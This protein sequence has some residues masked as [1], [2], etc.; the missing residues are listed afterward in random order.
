MKDYIKTR[1]TILTAW[2]ESR[3]LVLQSKNLDEFLLRS[4]GLLTLSRLLNLLRYTGDGTDPIRTGEWLNE[5][6]EI[7]E[8]VKK[9]I[10]KR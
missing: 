7:I 6:L 10:P 8:T 9:D 5:A 2:E 3:L 1:K 4:G